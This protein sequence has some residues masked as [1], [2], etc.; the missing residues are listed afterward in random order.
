[1]T[2]TMSIYQSN[3]ALHH[4]LPITLNI[5][6]P[7]TNHITHYTT[8]YLLHHVLHQQLPIISKKPKVEKAQLIKLVTSK[9]VNAIIMLELSLERK[10]KN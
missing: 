7:T 3:H 1:M 5:T 9:L 8:N 4:Q 10:K 2:V 6:S